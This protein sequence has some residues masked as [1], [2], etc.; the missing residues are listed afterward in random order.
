MLQKNNKTRKKQ[1]LIQANLGHFIHNLKT[2]CGNSKLFHAQF[3]I[4]F[5]SSF[6]KLENAPLNKVW[7]NSES[8]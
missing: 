6:S 1:I 5:W 8:F 4:F 3:H 7:K 2:N